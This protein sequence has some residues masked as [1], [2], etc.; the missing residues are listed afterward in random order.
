M[1]AKREGERREWNAQMG[2]GEGGGRE[3][4]EGGKGVGEVEGGGGMGES[5][6]AAEAWAK[7]VEVWS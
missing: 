1:G 6:W 5:C 3:G 2:D 4:G 7:G